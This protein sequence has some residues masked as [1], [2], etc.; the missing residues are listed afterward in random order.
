M[1]SAAA[2][3]V[4][5]NLVVAPH[6]DGDQV[7]LDHELTVDDLAAHA[8]MSRRNCTHRL[9]AATGTTAS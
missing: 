7:H 2:A 8:R 1:D 4:A 6:R 9:A 3:T 5:R